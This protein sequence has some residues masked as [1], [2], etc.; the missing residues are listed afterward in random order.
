MSFLRAD[1]EGRD[2]S[3]G[4]LGVLEMRKMPEADYYA[5]RPMLRYL[6]LLR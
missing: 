1:D 3:K 4:V 6:R 2:S 5:Q